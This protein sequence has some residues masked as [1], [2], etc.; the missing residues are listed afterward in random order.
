MV[1]AIFNEGARVALNGLSTQPT[2]NRERGVIVSRAGEACGGRLIRLDGGR[3]VYVDEINLALTE[4]SAAALVVEVTKTEPRTTNVVEA[5]AAQPEPQPSSEDEVEVEVED[6]GNAE[7]WLAEAMGGSPAASQR[8][9][10][11]PPSAERTGGTPPA[12]ESTPAPKREEARRGNR[13]ENAQRRRKLHSSVAPVAM[14]ALAT[15][16]S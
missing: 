7:Q 11:S 2:L 14:A 9:S 5:P 8:V 3:Y 10:T 13:R 4:R 12:R 15:A 16:H 1:K 6:E